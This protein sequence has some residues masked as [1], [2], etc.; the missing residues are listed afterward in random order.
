MLESAGIVVL[1]QTYP[2]GGWDSLVFRH[3]AQLWVRSFQVREDLEVAL[4]IWIAGGYT[5][6][7]SGKQTAGWAPPCGGNRAAGYV[8]MTY[9]W[10]KLNSR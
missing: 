5:H 10:G 9:L 4:L 8:N 2:S 1:R 3:S 7:K 6:V